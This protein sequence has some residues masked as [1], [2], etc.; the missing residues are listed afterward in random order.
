MTRQLLTLLTVLM[1]TTACSH[2]DS[3][4]TQ[5]PAPNG[6]A[7]RLQLTLVTGQ[8]PLTRASGDPG[9]EEEFEKPRYVYVFIVDTNNDKVAHTTLIDCTT[10]PVGITESTN[11]RGDRLWNYF[12]D[13]STPISVEQYKVYAVASDYELPQLEVIKEGD[14]ESTLLAATFDVPDSD[15]DHFLKN[16][17][18]TPSGQVKQQ[19]AASGSTILHVIDATLYHVAARVDLQWSVVDA[20]RSTLQ[21]STLTLQQMRGKDCLLFRPMDNEG[22]DPDPYI[23]I[24][25]LTPAQQWEGRH[26]FYAVPYFTD[27]NYPVSMAFNSGTLTHTENVA[28][29]ALDNDF[30]PWIRLRM[31]INRDY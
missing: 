19:T 24:I 9:T 11:D 18:S 5:P 20:R 7:T 27:G 14:P 31:N 17:Y 30:T 4:T 22:A 28:K 12:V 15:R 26:V 3:P 25:S 8:S 13:L 1:L 16:L 29:T 10:D 21:L 6:P 2:D 23:A